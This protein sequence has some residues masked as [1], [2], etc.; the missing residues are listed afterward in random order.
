MGHGHGLVAR[1]RPATEQEETQPIWRIIPLVSGPIDSD[2]PFE[3][4]ALGPRVEA[5]F[6]DH[7]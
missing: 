7:Q 3:L 5:V 2:L 6:P 1:V 4:A